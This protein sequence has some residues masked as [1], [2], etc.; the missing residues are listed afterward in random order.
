MKFALLTTL[1]EQPPGETQRTDERRGRSNDLCDVS[2]ARDNDHQSVWPSEASATVVTVA[3][4]K[5]CD[6]CAGAEV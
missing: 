1:T 3:A 6:A 2:S 4:C 5:G